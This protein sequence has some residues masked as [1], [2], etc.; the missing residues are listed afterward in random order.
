[1]SL[2]RSLVQLDSIH[3]QLRPPPSALLYYPMASGSYIKGIVISKHKD[4]LLAHET[5]YR[6]SKGDER[7]KIVEK[8]IEDIASQG[9]GKLSKPEAI[10]ILTPVSQFSHQWNPGSYPL[11]L[12]KL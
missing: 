6:S 3:H 9:K 8:I 5:D 4:I 11:G 7:Q 10:K 12:R 2:C 1:M